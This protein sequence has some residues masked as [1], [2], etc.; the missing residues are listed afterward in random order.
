MTNNRVWCT[1]CQRWLA[2]DQD[3]CPLFPDVLPPMTVR[4]LGY[5]IDTPMGTDDCKVIAGKKWGKCVCLVHT[6]HDAEF[7][8][9]YAS[10]GAGLKIHLTFWDK[11]A[12]CGS[13]PPTQGS[14]VTDP[15][16]EC[17]ID[18]ICKNCLREWQKLSIYKDFA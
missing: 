10:I 12:L 13:G 5:T 16:V 9:R 17:A 4:R 8:L 11:Y 1:S 15:Y 18:N 6:C 2:H 3:Y 14:L 7:K